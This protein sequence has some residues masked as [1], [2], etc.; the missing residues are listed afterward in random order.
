MGSTGYVFITTILNLSFTCCLNVLQDT[1]I[2]DLLSG[3]AGAVSACFVFVCFF[4]PGSGPQNG[5]RQF[6]AFVND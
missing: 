5:V 3:L 1:R 4:S 2:G 6:F